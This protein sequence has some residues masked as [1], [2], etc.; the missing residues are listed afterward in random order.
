MGRGV[1]SFDSS[2]A[3]CAWGGWASPPEPLV[4]LRGIPD[5]TSLALER[6]LASLPSAGPVGTVKLPLLTKGAP[7]QPHSNS[8]ACWT[9]SEFGD[10]YAGR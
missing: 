2:C 1:R 6:R 8:W 4:K 9:G 3:K 10:V 7:G 5:S